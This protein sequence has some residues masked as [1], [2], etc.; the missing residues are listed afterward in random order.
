VLDRMMRR[1]LLSL[2]NDAVEEARDAEER[3]SEI[4]ALPER[5]RDKRLT[6]LIKT[7]T[8]E[9]LIKH[10]RKLREQFLGDPDDEDIDLAVATALARLHW[11]RFFFVDDKT[12]PEELAFAITLFRR[13][14]A[15]GPAQIPVLLIPAVL[16]EDVPSK[17]GRD[18]DDLATLRAIA[19]N[20]LECGEEHWDGAA[21]TALAAAAL[22]ERLPSVTLNDRAETDEDVWLLA[23]CARHLFDHERMLT[24]GALAP[25]MAAPALHEATRTLRGE[26]ADDPILWAGHLHFGP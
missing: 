11:Y 1:L 8:D 26:Y 14:H 20:L 12:D 19:A 17:V 15:S 25:S 5:K 9:A 6:G 4:L 21:A 24:G 18:E 2:V 16:Q 7:L 3:W 22:A 23:S 10:A 13:V